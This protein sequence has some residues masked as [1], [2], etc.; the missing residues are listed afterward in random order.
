[1]AT[2]PYHGER[3]V[4]GRKNHAISQLLYYSLWGYVKS[5]VYAKM[6]INLDE[7][8]ANIN[9][10]TTRMNN[11]AHFGSSHQKWNRPLEAV[12]AKNDVLYNVIILCWNY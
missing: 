11:V 1:M 9:V 4:N 12:P 7:L 3:S 8:E 6:A 2:G 5:F 10:A